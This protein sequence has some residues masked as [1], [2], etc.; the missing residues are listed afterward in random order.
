MLHVKFV[1][2]YNLVSLNV[3]TLK[4]KEKL[5]KIYTYTHI[6]LNIIFFRFNMLQNSFSNRLNTRKSSKTLN[7]I[8]QKFCFSF[9]K[10]TLIITK[11]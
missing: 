6:L 9:G 4:K 7:K 11:G 8:A 1:Q 3:C 10:S 5:D 2:L